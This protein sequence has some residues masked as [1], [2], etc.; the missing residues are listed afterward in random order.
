MQYY[1]VKWCIM[2]Q[3]D[4]DRIRDTFQSCGSFWSIWV[5][6]TTTGKYIIANVYMQ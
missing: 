6:V 5:N 2:M 1:D 3:T 4:D